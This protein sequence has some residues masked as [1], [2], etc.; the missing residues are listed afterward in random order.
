MNNTHPIDHA[1]AL[2]FITAEAA[3]WI[4]NELLGLHTAPQATATATVTIDKAFILSLTVKQLRAH[5]GIK[6]SRY[7]KAALQA[8]ALGE[9]Y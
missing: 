1:L 6:S 4:I 5:T 3:L 7:N 8:I 2:L 9:G